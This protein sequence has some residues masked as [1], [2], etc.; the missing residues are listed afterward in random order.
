MHCADIND[1]YA[2]WEIF[3]THSHKLKKKTLSKNFDLVS[4]DEGHYVTRSC[5]GITLISPR[6]R[7]LT[8]D[9]FL[10]FEEGDQV[11]VCSMPNDFRRRW[12][13]LIVIILS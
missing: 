9:G 10:E 4:C 6:D 1:K 8:F 13:F 2:Y 3:C 11:P 12:L 7:E 5:S